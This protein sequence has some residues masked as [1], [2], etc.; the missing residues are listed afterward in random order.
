MTLKVLKITEYSCLFA[1]V[2]NATEIWH[3]KLQ[4]ELDFRRAEKQAFLKKG[5]REINPIN[6]NGAYY[7]SKHNRAWIEFNQETFEVDA[8][9]FK[10]LLLM[11]EAKEL[12]KEDIEA[13]SLIQKTKFRTKYHKDLFEAYSHNQEMKK[14]LKNANKFK[15]KAKKKLTL[16]KAQ[17]V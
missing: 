5:L 10:F 14:L 12:R 17:N 3:K 11:H 15:L 4:E 6:R 13:L 1:D 16:K 2:E 8:K 7:S 9:Y